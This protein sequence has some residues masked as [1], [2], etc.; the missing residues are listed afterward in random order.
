MPAASALWATGVSAAPSCGRT[1][2]ASGLSEITCSICCACESASAASS[3]RNLT[4]SYLSAAAFAFFE[5]APS[6]PWSVGGTLA[7][8]ETGPLL[9]CELPSPLVVC[10]VAAE[11][12]PPLSPSSSPH[13]A[14]PSASSIA[15]ASTVNRRKSDIVVLLLCRTYLSQ[16]R[17]G[18]L[19][20]HRPEDDRSLDHL[21]DLG[22]E[23][24][25][26]HQVEDER[27]RQHPEEGAADRR[28]AAGQARAADHHGADRVELV[29]VAAHRRGAAEAR[30]EQH[31][32]DPGEQARERVDAED[33]PP[34]RHAGDP[35]GIAVAADGDDLAP[36]ACPV[37]QDPACDC[38]PDEDEH[39]DRDADDLA[40]P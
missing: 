36:V 30:A 33:D 26:G 40:G 10:A 21:L 38:D 16:S 14:A 2:K 37:E 32:G 4:S 8:I 34:H 7:T 18:S 19:E 23:V 20:Q 5:I 27:E 28:P 22:R 25:L 15:T 17:L 9:V 29:E 24:Q 13:A 35:R 3:S 39:R 1:T 12:L 31:R 6:Q 11:P